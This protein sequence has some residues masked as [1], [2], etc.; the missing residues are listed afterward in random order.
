MNLPDIVIELERAHAFCEG[1]IHGLKVQ[2]RT[3]TNNCL[4][5]VIFVEE[6]TI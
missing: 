1:R 6:Y 2:N 5:N 3:E 4:G